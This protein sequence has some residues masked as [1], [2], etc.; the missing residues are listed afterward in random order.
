MGYKLRSGRGQKT[1]KTVEK[2]SRQSWLRVP[3]MVAIFLLPSAR[4]D[5]DQSLESAQGPRMELIRVTSEAYPDETYSIGL[6]TD[7]SG[8][9][10]AVYYS[11]PTAGSKAPYRRYPFAALA[12]PQLLIRVMNEYDLVKIR[13]NGMNLGVLYRQDVR[14]DRWKER[15]FQLECDSKMRGCHVLDLLTNRPVTQAYIASHYV[16]FLGVFKKAVGIKE[17]RV[18]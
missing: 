18:K 15:K 7:A 16:Y 6:E 4:A 1:M 5:E 9:A 11:D 17:I 14:Y 10:N 12:T 2:I 8:S 3:L 13:M